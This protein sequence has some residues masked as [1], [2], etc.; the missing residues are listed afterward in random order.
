[1]NILIKGGVSISVGSQLR[2]NG[3]ISNWLK[4]YTAK[5]YNYLE[6]PRLEPCHLQNADALLLQCSKYV[7]RDDSFDSS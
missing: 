6:N 2:K 3:I 7:F 5:S 4:H 1:M